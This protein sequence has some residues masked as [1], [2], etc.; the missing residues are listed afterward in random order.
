VNEK[1][2]QAAAS[3]AGAD[4]AEAVAKIHA[5]KQVARQNMAKQGKVEACDPPMGI[6]TEPRL[7]AWPD[8]LCDAEQLVRQKPIWAR[9]IKGTPLEND[10]PVWIADFA[11]RTLQRERARVAANGMEAIDQIRAGIA[12]DRCDGESEFAAGVNAACRNHLEL[13]DA[14][15]VSATQAATAKE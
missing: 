5:A 13:I 3:Q 7:P 9:F 12:A 8:V 15:R 10:V 11:Q 4:Y 14:R 2:I 6:D 1:H